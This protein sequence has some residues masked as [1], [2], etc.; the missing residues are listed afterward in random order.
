MV[1]QVGSAGPVVL[2]DELVQHPAL[3]TKPLLHVSGSAM[4]DVT[5]LRSEAFACFATWR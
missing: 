3:Y 2:D 4:P 5:L 1:P